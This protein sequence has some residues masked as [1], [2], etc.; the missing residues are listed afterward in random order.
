M[1]ALFMRERIFDDPTLPPPGKRSGA[2]SASILPYLLKTL[3]TRP[4]GPLID[5]PHPGEPVRHDSVA[6]MARPE[7]GK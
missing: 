7:H 6:R 4:Q 1:C 5:E 2:G 3:A